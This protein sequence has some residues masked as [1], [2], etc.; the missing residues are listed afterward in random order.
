MVVFPLVST[1]LHPVSHSHSALLMMFWSSC[2]P[3]VVKV[4]P[5]FLAA[6]VQST[7]GALALHVA[8][9][10]RATPEAHAQRRT[11][12][13]VCERI[14]GCLCK[15]GTERWDA[16]GQGRPGR[17]GI[18]AMSSRHDGRRSGGQGGSECSQRP[19]DGQIA[20][21]S[22]AGALCDGRTTS[23]ASAS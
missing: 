10:A 16:A 20:D 11:R 15:R 8:L 9:S 21:R 2:V 3:T 7:C 18:I 13:R 17:R 5:P 4:P 6:T 23:R 1:V 19:D 14:A 12:A 22:S